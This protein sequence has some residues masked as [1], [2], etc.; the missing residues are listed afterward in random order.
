MSGQMRPAQPLERRPLHEQIADRLRELIDDQQLQPGDK[1]TPE[2]ELAVQLGVSRH[3]IRQALAALR[4]IGLLEIRH[5]DGVYLARS[6]NELVPMLAQQLAETQAEF[7]HIWEVRQAIESQSARLAA[8]R[9]TD[10]DLDAIGAAVTAM[11][12]SIDAGDQ[13]TDADHD[14]HHAVADAAHNPLIT[15]LMRE[16]AEAFASTSGASLAKPGQP[17]RSLAD[18]RAIAEAIASGDEDAAGAA[19]LAHLQRTT[20]LAFEDEG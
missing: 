1:I 8:R 9:R 18:H 6:P 19:M 11:A 7:P 2:R 16:L 10:D 12:A 5:G 3:S 4:A 15:M 14:F 13:G 17:A 20:A